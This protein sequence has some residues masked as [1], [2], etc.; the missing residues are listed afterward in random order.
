MQTASVQYDEKLVAA[1]GS[2]GRMEHPQSMLPYIT[3]K[4]KLGNVTGLSVLDLACGDGHTTRM[5]ARMGAH[6]VIGVDI[7]PE[8]IRRAQ[9]IEEK[10]KL[11][12]R[13][14]VQDVEALRLGRTFD[15]V[16]PTFLFHYA[17][18]K[19]RMYRLMRRTAEHVRSEG[20]MV[21]LTA[22]P[23]PVVPRF[24]NASHSVEWEG[25]PGLEG[26]KLRMYIY[27]LEG[28]DVCNFQYYFWKPQTYDKLLYE[29]GFRGMTWFGHTMPPEMRIQFSN[30]D[31]LEKNNG[32]AVIVAW[33]RKYRIR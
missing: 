2:M 12:V 14:I 24:P 13:Y 6:E 5:L 21:A 10:E 11:G 31:Q 33:R 26:S 23:E 16:T 3:W 25:T 28:K 27:D 20:R 4:R 15:L 1:Y 17:E 8:Q 29:A 30:W 18:T 19:D 9:A 32:S 22:S 7:S